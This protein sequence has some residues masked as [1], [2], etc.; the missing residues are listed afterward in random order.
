MRCFKHSTY[1]FLL[2]GLSLLAHSPLSAEQGEIENQFS[3]DAQ[4]RPRA[5]FRHGVFQPLPSKDS[6]PAALISQRTRFTLNYQYKNLLQVKITPQMVSVWGQENMNQG[7]ASSN[8]LTFFEAYARL[9]LKPNSGFVI[10]RQVI[11]LDDER[12]FGELDWAQGGRSHDAISYQLSRPKGEF[13][14][15][16]SF[17]QNYREVYGN[18]LGNVSG[19]EFS[20]VGASSYKWMQ[21]AWGQ[22]NINDHHAIS[23]LIANI[24]FQD[25]DQADGWEGKAKTY[26]S[27]TMGI[28]YK[29]QKDGWK[30]NLSVYYQ[31]GKNAMG[32]S[33][34][35]YLASIKMDKAINEKWAVGAGADLVSGNDIKSQSSSK[36]R[37]FIPYFG[38]NH[39]FY[40]F[41][42]YYY[43]GN[44]HKGSGLVDL[45]A[46]ASFQPTSKLQLSLVFHQFLSPNKIKS[47]DDTKFKQNMGQEIDL[48]INYDIHKFAKLMGGYS[49]YASSN[50]LD[51]L[52]NTPQA[53]A[54]Q[55]WLWLSLNINPKLFEIKK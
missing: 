40:G 12:F 47:I 18:N 49:L 21:T 29:H 27:P 23:A 45:N 26:F 52:K 3:M 53:T 15:Y 43:A 2:A 9:N 37:A 38:T 32:A 16:F 17:N 48:G 24:G 1:S 19:N 6:K 25:A 36:N 39:K 22:Y 44:G 50:T 5:E 54:T 14:S 35:A 33:T 10:G 51:F 41:M 7:A 20:P 4:L 46:Q 34:Q 31:T 28:N 11:S 8:A 42:D 30:V 13:K 55:H